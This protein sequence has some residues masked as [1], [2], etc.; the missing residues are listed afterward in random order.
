MNTKQYLSLFSSACFIVACYVLIGCGGGGGLDA[1][2][3]GSVN[4]TGGVPQELLDAAAKNSDTTVGGG[5]TD[6]G[7]TGS[8][9]DSG[10]GDSGSGTSGGGTSGG[11][12]SGGGTSGGGTSGGGTSGGGTSGGGTSGSV[13]DDPLAG[14]PTSGTKWFSYHVKEGNGGSMFVSTYDGMQ[15]YR[16]G[17]NGW[18]PSF[19]RDYSKMVFWRPIPNSI[20]IKNSLGVETNLGSGISP[21]INA[22]GTKIVFQD[23]A[24]AGSWDIFTMD[25]DGSNRQQLTFD[26]SVEAAPTFSHDGQQICY[27]RLPAK[28]EALVPLAR[29]MVLPTSGGTPVDI[30]PTDRWGLLGM[31]VNNDQSVMYVGGELGKGSKRYVKGIQES[32]LGQQVSFSG[33]IFTVT[34]DGSTIIHSTGGK[35][36]YA[37]TIYRTDVLTGT[38]T[39]IGNGIVNNSPIYD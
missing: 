4:L 26:P 25:A 5:T 37:P 23:R 34:P 29:I 28:G 33:T 16:V 2:I 38:T 6:S 27:L 11:G 3:G 19:S 24:T 14:W 20:I 36:T 18:Y 12:T 21:I 8:S 39:A 30:I 17:K 31:F 32:G 10:T 7:T 15:I 35:S 22:D 1:G 9:G 13:P